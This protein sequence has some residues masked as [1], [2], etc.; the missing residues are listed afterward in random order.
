MIVGSMWISH[1]VFP[2]IDGKEKV[3]WKFLM[4]KKKKIEKIILPKVQRISE[5]II[6]DDHQE[7]VVR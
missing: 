3:V 4:M 2:N 6:K 1:K 7:I 5:V